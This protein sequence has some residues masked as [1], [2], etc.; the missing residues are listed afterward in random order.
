MG[1]LLRGKASSDQDGGG[2]EQGSALGGISRQNVP[3]KAN[4]VTLGPRTQ[5]GA[6]GSPGVPVPVYSR[7]MGGMWSPLHGTDT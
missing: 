5:G 6:A 3:D 1:G 4:Q 7:T 2:W